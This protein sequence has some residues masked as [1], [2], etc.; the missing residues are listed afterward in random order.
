MKKIN[1]NNLYIVEYHHRIAI[2]FIVE[3]L[4]LNELYAHIKNKIFTLFDL[5]IIARELNEKLC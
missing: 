4:I 2:Y 3:K 1:L 5:Q